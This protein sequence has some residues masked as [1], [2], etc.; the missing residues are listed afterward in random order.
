MLETR[1][2]KTAAHYPQVIP[3]GSAHCFKE[4]AVRSP[5]TTQNFLEQFAGERG[6]RDYP[7]ALGSPTRKRGRFQELPSFNPR[8]YLARDTTHITWDDSSEPLADD[9]TNQSTAQNEFR[10]GIFNLQVIR[11]AEKALRQDDLAFA[12]RNPPLA[13]IVRG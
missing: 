4:K 7:S 10:C 8:G 2:R 3:G 1:A 13:Q 11:L 6:A 9:V 12:E 5:L